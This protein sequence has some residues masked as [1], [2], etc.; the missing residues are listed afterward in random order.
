MID[1]LIATT[2]GSGNE[3]ALDEMLALIAP[4]EGKPVE[5][6]QLAALV[7]L[8][9]A[10]H[11]R[12]QDLESLSAS[13][14]AEGRLALGHIQQAFAGARSIAQ[15][16]SDDEATRMAAIGLLGRSPGQ[17]DA[18]VA[19][20]KKL[21]APPTPSRLQTAAVAALGRTRS[22]KAPQPGWDHGLVDFSERPNLEIGNPEHQS[23]RFVF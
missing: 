16:D 23:F 20:L 8:M 14:S 3:K 5:P 1:Q 15:N 2:V 4:D 7:G 13:A 19:L 6:W 12:G 22:P 17:F 11:R 9:D 21:L 18:D 10:V